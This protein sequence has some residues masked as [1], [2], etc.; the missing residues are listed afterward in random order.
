MIVGAKFLTWAPVTGGGAGAAVTYSGGA[1][2][3]DKLVKVDMS[4]ERADTGFYADD[5][6]IDRDNSIN[7][8][9]VSI[10]VA[11]LTL[12]MREGMLGHVKSSNDYTVTDAA[13]PFVGVG[14]CLKERYKGTVTYR[15]YW[16]YKVQFSEGQR[17]FNTKGENLE[18]QTESLE[19]AVEAVQ[20]T[21]GGKFE[22]YVYADFD[23]EAAAD[24][25]LKGK[26]NVSGNQ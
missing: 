7:S 8:A 15:T 23:T 14:F 1:L 20:L 12:E 10:E 5:H 21:D 6:R 13:S 26:G 18:F 19:G 24:T 2:E 25:W 4:E 22:Y 11:Q 16:Y 9:S 3:T 17:S